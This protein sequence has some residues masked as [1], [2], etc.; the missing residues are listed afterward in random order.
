AR[1]TP[2]SARRRRGRRRASRPAPAS[3]AR[4]APA[5]RRCHPRP[6]PP[7]IS[8]RTEGPFSTTLHQGRRAGAHLLPAGRPHSPRRAFRCARATPAAGRAAAFGL[9]VLLPLL[10]ELRR[11]RNQNNDPCT[12]TT[13]YE[14]SVQNT[15]SATITPT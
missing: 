7:E 6:T 3:A 11:D 4:P 13:R 8:W 9:S 14:K 2:A 15:V 1:A 5:A 12:M 10:A